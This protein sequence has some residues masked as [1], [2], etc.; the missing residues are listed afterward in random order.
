M[1]NNYLSNEFP[2]LGGKFFDFSA[3][4]NISIN[5]IVYHKL[6]HRWTLEVIGGTTPPPENQISPLL[7]L[8]EN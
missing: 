3:E 5:K 6:N 1:L 8:N 7:Q 2:G 4:V